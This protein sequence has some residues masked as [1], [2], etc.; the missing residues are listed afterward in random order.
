MAAITPIAAPVPAPNADAHQQKGATAAVDF[1]GA[2][3]HRDLVRAKLRV[4]PAS[5]AQKKMAS[6]NVRARERP[7]EREPEDDS[8]GQYVDINV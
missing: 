7:P 8:K 1:G 4:D 5:V 2:V 6:E 3:T